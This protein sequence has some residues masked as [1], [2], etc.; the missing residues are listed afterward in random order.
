MPLSKHSPELLHTVNLYYVTPSHVKIT[1]KWVVRVFSEHLHENGR[2]MV[3]E[4]LVDKVNKTF[5]I[6][7]K[8]K[9]KI[10]IHAK[11]SD[12][13]MM[14]LAC[15]TSMTSTL[16]YRNPDSPSVCPVNVYTFCIAR[17]D[18]SCSICLNSVCDRQV[19]IKNCYCIFHRC[20]IRE[21]YLHS[22]ACPVCSIDMNYTRFDRDL[23]VNEVLV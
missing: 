17:K 1:K 2:V 8:V 13:E 5:S 20:C 11:L 19:R 7:K 12:V 23:N 9:T 4:E 14:A 3:N 16:E 10:T 6:R 22:H 18:W 15:N 21:A